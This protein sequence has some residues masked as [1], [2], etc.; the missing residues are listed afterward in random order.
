MST[1][2]PTTPIP[3]FEDE[4]PAGTPQ[5]TDATPQGALLAWVRRTESRVLDMLSIIGLP[6]LR[7]SLA[8]VYVA[9]GGLKI[10][11]LSPVADLVALMLP[12]LPADVAV[13]GMGVFEVAVG[14][15]LAAG[16]LVPWVAAS[17]VVHLAGT[18]L[19]FLVHPALAFVDGNPLALTVLGEFVAKNVVLV[20]GLLVVAAFS[21]SRG[22]RAS[23]A[24]RA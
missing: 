9:F 21:G 16:V 6:L 10:V 11:G 23:R 13:I 24:A 3:T 17:Q 5:I 19:I 2:T 20:A 15:L 18:F 22:I 14:L 8:F 12:F 7:L 1:L 4:R